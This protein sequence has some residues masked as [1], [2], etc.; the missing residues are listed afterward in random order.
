MIYYLSQRETGK[1][2]PVSPI[3]RLRAEGGFA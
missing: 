3:L 2:K 1:A